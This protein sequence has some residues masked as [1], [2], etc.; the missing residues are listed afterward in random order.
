MAGTHTVTYQGE[1][2]V[3][4]D[5][6]PDTIL[7]RGVSRSGRGTRPTVLC[8][9]CQREKFQYSK[10]CEA[11]GLVGRLAARDLILAGLCVAEY[12]A[13]V[14]V[15]GDFARARAN[16]EYRLEAMLTVMLAGKKGR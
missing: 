11:W 16:T 2:V 3:V 10:G 6:H 14:R 1:S 7:S 15:E 12:G 4:C 9:Y 13:A 5:A 8:E